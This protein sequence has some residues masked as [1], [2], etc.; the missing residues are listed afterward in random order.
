MDSQT[1][2]ELVSFVALDV[3]VQQREGTPTLL[4]DAQGIVH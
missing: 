1:A 4:E 3:Q 2:K